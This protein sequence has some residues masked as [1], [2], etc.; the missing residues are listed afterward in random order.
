[1]KTEFTKEFSLTEE[2]R[3]CYETEQVEALPFGNGTI[4][5]RKLFDA[6]PIKDFIWVVTTHCEMTE[7]EL[8][9][10]TI[11]ALEFVK[12]E[13]GKEE[14]KKKKIVDCLDV[15]IKYLSDAT[16]S[17]TD[18]TAYW[19]AYR[20]TDSDADRAAYGSSYGSAYG[21]ADKAADRSAYWAAYWAAPFKT[22]IEN[23]FFNQ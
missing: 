16:D 12:I 11:A 20:A 5:L 3:G 1:M 13:Y 17:A 22:M 18:W 21:S 23:Y 10:F 8:K 19:A 4:T 15:T 6:L 7:E 9:A 14:D 2:G